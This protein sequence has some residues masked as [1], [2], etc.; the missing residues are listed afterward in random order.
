MA[1]LR[2]KTAIHPKTGKVYAELYYPDDQVVPIA[3]TEP[4][5]PNSEVAVRQSIEMFKDWMSL[6]REE[7]V[8][9]K[10]VECD[11]LVYFDGKH[12]LCLKA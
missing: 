11:C 5:Y 8:D 12:K 6:L 9:G 2:V 10:M 3:I 1:N 4:I 7:L